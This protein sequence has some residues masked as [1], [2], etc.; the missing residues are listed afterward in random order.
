MSDITVKYKGSP[1]ATMD[2]SGMKTLETQGK[3]CEGDIDIE[4]VKPNGSSYVKLA[5]TEV[6][7][8]TTSSSVAI[9]ANIDINPASDAW[10]S[11]KMLYVRIRDKAGNRDGHFCGSDSIIVNPFAINGATTTVT[12]AMARIL[13]A[14]PAS[15]DYLLSAQGYGVY[16]Y[17]INNTG[18]IRIASRYSPSTSLTIDGTYTIE[19]YALKYPD[20]VS[21]F[22]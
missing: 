6:A 10:T 12:T 22:V 9:V 1:I 17:D 20:N 16:V 7:V 15:G 4:Y 11:A 21:P 19:V 5:E 2:A 8:D 13:F 18:R 14:K 3:Y